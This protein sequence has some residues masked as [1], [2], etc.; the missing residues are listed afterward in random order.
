MANAFQN[1]INKNAKPAPKPKSKSTNKVYLDVPKKVMDA[2]D[3]FQKAK[4]AKK[5]AEAEM[6]F[7]EAVIIEA[8]K[9][10]QD[11]DG[12]NNDYKKSY[13]VKGNQTDAKY[14]TQNRASISEE[15][16]DEI[17]NMLGSDY[18]F[19]IVEN[20][21]VQLKKEVFDSEKM[22]EELMSLL[23]EENFA[24]FFDTSK[25]LAVADDYDKNIYGVVK[26][27]KE[28]DKVR[29]FVRPYKAAVR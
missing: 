4:K 11:K 8:V 19:L 3:A 1:A 25:K 22:Q 6:S 7:N 13:N 29:T 27:Q 28:L 18:D 9:P 12:F 16:E 2:V 26:D 23:G 17:R 14:V 24:K 10:E 20:H 21:T 5:E 15:D